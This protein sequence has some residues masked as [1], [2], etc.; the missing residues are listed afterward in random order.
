LVFTANGVWNKNELFTL[1]TDTYIVTG[2]SYPVKQSFMGQ[3]FYSD[4]CYISFNDTIIINENTTNVVLNANYAC[5]L[6]LVDKINVSQTKIN[7]G[8]PDFLM[9]CTENFYHVYVNHLY[10]Y[11]GMSIIKIYDNSGF[12]SYINLDVFPWKFSKF[13][14]FDSVGGTY[15]LLPMTN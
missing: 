5:F 1:P 4:T 11:T 3:N 6:I 14:Y 8:N 9:K 2:V 7:I 12:I 15:S 13:Y 10:E